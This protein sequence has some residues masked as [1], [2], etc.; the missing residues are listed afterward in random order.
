M[1][2]SCWILLSFFLYHALA[3]QSDT[4]KKYSNGNIL[5]HNKGN[6]QLLSPGGAELGSWKETT[7]NIKK[8]DKSLSIVRRTD[9]TEKKRTGIFDQLNGVFILP[10]EY[11]QLIQADYNKGIFETRIG[12]KYG[13]FS[14]ATGKL[15]PAVFDFARKHLNPNWYIVC[16]SGARNCGYVYNDQFQLLDSFP[17]MKSVRNRIV[18]GNRE[19]FHI[20]MAEGQGLLD[21]ENKLVYRKEWKN[22]HDIK[23]VTAIVNNG[24]GIGLFDLASDKLV[25][26]YSFTDYWPDYFN[27]QGFLRK[28]NQWVLIDQLG[29]TLFSFIADDVEF[30]QREETGGFYFKQK[31]LWGVM[32]NNGK[33]VRTPVWQS[34][35]PG[36][37]GGFIGK[38]PGKT[39]IYYGG[40][41]KL[42]K[43]EKVLTA[44]RELNAVEITTAYPD[45]ANWVRDEPKEMAIIATLPDAP[46]PPASEE[47]NK[48]YIKM[49]IDPTFPRGSQTEEVYFRNAIDQYKKE[50]GIKK[51]GR[52][53]LRL[54][55]EKDGS[56][57]LIETVSSTDAT[58]TDASKALLKTI[59]NWKAGQQNGGPVRGEK[60]LVL[61]W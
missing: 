41:Y 33:I 26:P 25:K 61:E 46:G 39:E 14:A 31:G 7:Q 1:K 36:S 11:E 55:I 42:N 28:G 29:K 43:G 12:K 19:W 40:V 17:G 23:G 57:S 5:L 24:E 50:K 44:I 60:T 48:I 51:K 15:L 30:S 34:V 18:S 27:S 56:V 35:I 2:R 21:K 54:V 59:S 6:M 47:Q 3:A 10:M 22:I 58:L 8:W 52:V 16:V 53:T 13:Y 32:N 9:S 37:S 20:N 4:V 45:Q 49:E 38:Y